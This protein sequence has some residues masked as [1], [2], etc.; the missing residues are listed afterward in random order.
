LFCFFYRQKFENEKAARE[1]VEM[2]R[3]RLLEQI[4][5]L[6]LAQEKQAKGRCEW[7]NL[8]I[9]EGIVVWTLFINGGCFMFVLICTRTKE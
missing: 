5:V 3:R 4:E 9:E 8:S 2:E 1:K 6:T 7:A